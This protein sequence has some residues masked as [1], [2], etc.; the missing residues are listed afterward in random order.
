MGPYRRDMGRARR[1]VE[2]NGIYHVVCRGNNKQPIFDDDLRSWYR[3]Q[4]GQI[5]RRHDWSVYAWA[6]MT[7]HVHLVLHIGDSGISDGMRELN[8]YLA[9]A[10][11]ARFGRI[12]HCLGRRYWSEL[13][14]DDAQ[15]YSVIRYVLWNPAR[16]GLEEQPGRCRWTSFRVTVGLEWATEP[17]DVARLLRHFGTAP[18]TARPS[19]ERFV[20]ADGLR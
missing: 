1:V 6:L 15:L 5:A 18:E 10:S 2:P 4:L 14:E 7:N 17:L 8:T 12:N 13:V 19:F 16:A 9:R 20:L 11:N 3:W